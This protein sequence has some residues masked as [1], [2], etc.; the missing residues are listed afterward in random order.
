MK[1]II[2][3]LLL[4][5]AIM[6]GVQTRAQ[7]VGLKTN[8]LYGAYTY[9]PNLGV[10][11][12]LGQKTTLDLGGGY[13]PWHRD[14]SGVDNKK[15]VHWLAEA[16]FRYWTCERFNGLFF[17][18]HALGS[19]YNISHHKLPWLLGKDSNKYRYDGYAVGGGLSI[20]YQFI[21]GNRWNLEATVGVGYAR[22]KYDKYD[23]TKCGRKLESNVSRN[24]FGPTKAGISIIFL[25]N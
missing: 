21:L 11:I 1:K 14:G 25:F 15:L 7:S 6:L 8:L 3:V 22:L 16:E 23:C 13:N 17:G 10:E 5:S 19:Q 2:S 24:Y 12:G 20:G 9:T 18:V 4:L